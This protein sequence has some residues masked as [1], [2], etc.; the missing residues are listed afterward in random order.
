VKRRA[1]LKRSDYPVRLLADRRRLSFEQIRQE[2]SWLLEAIPETEAS[3]ERYADL[4]DFAPVG[5]L[6]LDRNG[7]IRDINLTG[8][9][10]L[11]RTRSLLLGHP[12]LPL[13]EK[14]D[15]RKFLNHLSR[16]RQ[17]Q[18]QTVT[19]LSIAPKGDKPF[20]AQLISIASRQAGAH[21]TQ[22][23][24][25]MLDVGERKRAEAALRESEERLRLALAGGQMGMWEMDLAS[26]R[27]YVDSLE[28]RLLG[29]EIV[30]KDFTNEQFLHRVHP[31]DREELVKRIR[32]TVQAGGD[33]QSEFRLAPVRNG[34]ERWIAATGTVARSEQGKPTRLLGVNFDVTQ[35]KQA[36]V[37]LRR[38][39]NELEQRVA[40]RTDELARINQ[41]LQVEITERQQ[42][43][44][45]LRESEQALADFF[46]HATIG[47]QWLDRRGRVLRINQAALDLLG[48]SRA[49][50]LH[51]PVAPFFADREALAVM[52]DRL[53]RGETLR[54]FFMRIQRRDGSVRH[55]LIDAD[56]SWQNQRLIRTR[57]FI[58]DISERVLLQA[59]IVA[60]GERE[61]QRIGQDLHDG[62]CQL[63][64]G[65]RWKSQLIQERLALSDPA[66]ARKVRKITA[67]LTDAIKQARGLVRGL[68]P[69]ENVPDGLMSALQQLAG[70]TRELFGVA[71]R[72][73][74]VRPVLVSE[75]SAATDLFR[76]A[77]E[78]IN[79]AIKHARAKRIQIELA[80]NNGNIVLRVTNDGRPFPRRAKTT[81]AGLKIMHHRARRIGAALQFSVDERDGTSV[82]CSMPVPES[83]RAGDPYL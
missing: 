44:A 55:L 18:P 71:C 35:R 50:C 46:E 31:E 36:E 40:S 42:A 37:A 39:H 67:L 51:R 33:F 25:A 7:C 72:F 70:S 81:G 21:A 65:I 32:N 38:T 1:I 27:A 17:G 47:I 14:P 3:R 83:S 63:L 43:E 82:T 9:R 26:G 73:D 69:V 59:E 53:G 56:G 41:R 4:Y 74:V 20:I 12:L 30:P 80:Q 6:T 22:F 13:I 28:A 45:A 48:C 29:M 77:Q 5:Y 64:T 58:R 8:A 34:D 52:L 76:I 15:R 62:L 54:D 61:R 66:E 24:T 60:A 49:E 79:N 19:E 78:A 2:W 10:L 68:Q 57:W 16:L 75:Q 11:G 23:R